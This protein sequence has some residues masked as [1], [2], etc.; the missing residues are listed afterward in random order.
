ME[1]RL[2]I[3]EASEAQISVVFVVL[4]F[5]FGVLRTQLRMV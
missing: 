4:E 2:E 5:S 1:A 3:R